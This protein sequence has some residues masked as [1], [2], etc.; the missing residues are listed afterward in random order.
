M[1]SEDLH[2]TVSGLPAG[3]LLTCI[4]P[5]RVN[6]ERGDAFERVTYFQL[7]TRLPK[8]VGF[9]VVDDGS[10][11]QAGGSW[12]RFAPASGSA[13]SASKA[14]RVRLRWGAVE[15]SARCMRVRNMC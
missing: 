5:L 10:P 15:T 8:E 2:V 6:P 13:T 3:K 14:R 7:D 9:I 1:S 11:A 4:I 12:S